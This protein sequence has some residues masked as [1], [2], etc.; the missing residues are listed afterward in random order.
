MSKK[1]K[2]RGAVVSALSLSMAL[3]SLSV[4]SAQSV[5]DVQGHWAE[6]Q[7]QSWIENGSL[8]GYQDGSVKPNNSITRAEFITLVNRMFGFTDPSAADFKDLSPSNWAY[9]DVAKAVNAG[10]VKGYSDNTFH[11]GSNVSRQEAATMISNILGLNTSNTEEIKQFT[12]AGKIPTWSQ[13]SVA[14]VIE[15][16]IM[17]GYPDGTFQAQ[18]QLTRAE[19]V[20]L[21]ES[22][23]SNREVAAETVTIDKAGIHGNMQETKIVNGDVI[24]NVPGVTLENYEIKGNLLLAAG[25]GSGDVTIKNVK[26]HG[27]TNVEGGGENSIHFVDSVL[28]NILVNKK[29]GTVRLVAEGTTKAQKVI[30]QS[31]AKLEESDL[32]GEGFTDVELAKE[33]PANATVQ[34]N[35]KFDDVDIFSAS[36]SVKLLSGSIQDVTVDAAAANN[37]IQLSSGAQVVNLVLN[38][39]S[40]LLGA[41][42]ITTVTLNSGSQNSTFDARPSNVQGDQKGSIIVNTPSTATSSSSGSSSSGGSGGGSTGGGGDQTKVTYTV[43]FNLN[44]A[45]GTAPTAATVEAGKTVTLPAAPTRAGYTFAGWNTVADGSGTSV[46]GTTVINGNITAYAQWHLAAPANGLKTLN[47]ARVTETGA[48]FLAAGLVNESGS[49][50][51]STLREIKD[52]IEDKYDV[53]F[54]AEAISVVDGQISI[55]GSVL[56]PADWAKVKANGNK[57][58]PYRITLVEDGTKVK[59]AKIAMYQDGNAVIESFQAEEV[60][61][62]TV[63]FDLNGANDTAPTAATVEAGKTVTLPAEPTREGY[64]FAGWNTVADGSGTSVDGTTVINGNITAYAQWHLAAPANGLKTLNVARVTETG[65]KFLAAGLVNESGSEVAS[66]L[67]EI[68]DYI[69]DKYDVSFNAEAISVV[70][71]KISITGSVLSSADWAKVKAN[72]N[73]TIPYRITLVE[74]GTKV[75]AAKIAM[76]QDGNAVI[77][78]FQAEEVTQYTVSFDLN[79]ADGTAPTAATVEAGKTVTLP[80]EPTREGYAF[81][82]WNTVA[83][84]SGTSVNGTTVINEN[85]MVYAQW[86]LAAPANGLKTLNVARVTE[87]GA[88]F[89]AAGL[90]NES[91]AEVASALGEIKEYIENKYGVLFNTDMISVVDGKISITG[92]VL[93]PADWAKVKANGNKTI[94]YRITLLEDGTKVKAA[95]IAMYQDGNAVI[96][97]LQSEEVTQYTVSFDLNGANGTAPTAATVEA[98]KTVTLPAAPTRE[99]Y[100]FAGWNTGAD[101]SGVTVDGTTAINANTTL[102]AQ[103]EAQLVAPTDGLNELEISNVTV[104]EAKFLVFGLNKENSD[105]QKPSTLDEA[106]TFINGKYE[107]VFNAD[108][109]KLE[110]GKISITGSILNTADWNKVKTNG[111]KTVP[112]RI[113]LLDDAGVKVAKVAMYQDGKAV[114]ETLN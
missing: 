73:K 64:A 19:A 24:I 9:N 106:K 61:Q 40:K 110:N 53:S 111:N 21:I 84:G 60:T 113:T 96:E 22:A 93:S 54:N 114:I 58:I 50:V 18:K 89:L 35:G 70:D 20:V 28:V 107:V 52:Y 98:G 36:V 3:S 101:G 5:N 90:V 12:D 6:Q 15:K 2:L 88:K 47:V 62:Y 16:G 27:T 29:D 99:G 76:Y 79:G 17:K 80:A 100:T 108:A 46:D 43:A 78:S 74:D 37:T 95:K 72:G 41:S 104:A 25:I 75:K 38:A 33:L 49:E 81:A 23:M 102:Y 85:T 97:S 44:G 11:P 67:R 77:E 31:S 71:G 13:G 8:K 86:H 39:I 30:V 112:Y 26:V 82:G 34:L 42:N 103:W 51:A 10:Y 109:I 45:D 55:T 59:A 32:N 94:P 1:K 4:V 87:T 7:I 14:A 66:T 48:K 65:A 105:A 57:T 63:S 91:G 56:S 68:K 83:D 92:S 69:E